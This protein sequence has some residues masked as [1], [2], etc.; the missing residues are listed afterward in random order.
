MTQKIELYS[1]WDPRNYMTEF[2]GFMIFLLASFMTIGF[3]EVIHGMAIALAV[4][5]FLW[6]VKSFFD[7]VRRDK[8]RK[9]RK[10][11]K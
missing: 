9:E 3:D 2:V 5:F 8:V 10:A 11:A 7:E 1:I 6:L 4:V